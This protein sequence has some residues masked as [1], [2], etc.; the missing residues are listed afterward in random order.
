MLVRNKGEGQEPEILDNDVFGLLIR[1]KDASCNEGGVN[2][3]FAV[4]DH[5]KLF[6]DSKMD[7]FEEIMPH[8]DELL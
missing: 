4:M 8:V 1:T 7:N 6:D 2:S 3:G 5:V